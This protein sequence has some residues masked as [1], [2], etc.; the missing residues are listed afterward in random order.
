MKSLNGQRF[1]S[2]DTVAAEFTR[3]GHIASRRIATT[4]HLA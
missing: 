2:L 3:A 4:V 1:Q